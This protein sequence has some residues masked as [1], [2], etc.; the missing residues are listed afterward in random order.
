MREASLKHQPLAWKRPSRGSSAEGE[1]LGL[2]GRWTLATAFSVRRCGG[3]LGD[4]NPSVLKMLGNTLDE[5]PRVSL[6]ESQAESDDPISRPSS[7]EVPQTNSDSR[8][9]L[10]GEIARGGMGAIIKGRDTDLGRDLAI[11]VLLDSHKDKPEVI[12]RFVEEAQIGGQ[13]QHPGIAPVYELGQFADQRPFFSMKLVKGDTLSKLLSNRDDPAADRGKLIGVFEQVCQTMAYAHSRG[14]IHRDL[15]PANIMVG[16]FGEVQ[17]MDWGLAKVLSCWWSGRREN[18][19]QE[20]KR[21]DDDPN[22]A[23]R[24][25]RCSRLGRLSGI[26]NADGERNGHAS[27]HAAGAGSRRD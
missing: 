17:V 22:H 9:R 7:P 10:D 20:A 8:Y 24:R 4:A 1:S 19:S 5:V 2:A 27:V 18:G 26:G 12:Q 13:L 11:K 14:V 3:D 25:Q 21:R 16:A 6:R 23:E 15:K